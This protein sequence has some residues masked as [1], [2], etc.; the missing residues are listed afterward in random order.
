MCMSPSVFGD[1]ED[2][3][4]WHLI[5]LFL[6]RLLVLYCYFSYWL[7]LP[8]HQLWL[9]LWYQMLRF[10]M[11]WSAV[12][13]KLH[14]WILTWA[15]PLWC[16]LQNTSNLLLFFVSYLQAFPGSAASPKPHLSLKEAVQSWTVKWTLTLRRL[17]GGSRTGSRSSWMSVC[18]S[19]PAELSSSAMLLTRMEASIA[20]SLRAG[21]PPSTAMKQSSKFCQ[22][23]TCFSFK[24]E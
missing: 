5:C 8:S 13:L 21:G 6:K 11:S 10:L 17:W 15:S 2:F 14:S 20:A 22:V 18:S 3:C 1:S 23:L 19:Y 12:F 16:H 9:V 4:Y 7:R 24:N